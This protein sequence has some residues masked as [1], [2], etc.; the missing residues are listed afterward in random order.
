[1]ALI[2]IC[3]LPIKT[4]TK[5]YTTRTLILSLRYFQV[6]TF[7]HKCLLSVERLLLEYIDGKNK[8]YI[9]EIAQVKILEKITE[10]SKSDI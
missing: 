2:E 7:L 4:Y 8:S 9:F 10:I 3:A 6:T 5:M 1:L